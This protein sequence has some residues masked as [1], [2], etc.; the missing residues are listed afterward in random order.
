MPWSCSKKSPQLEGCG[1]QEGAILRVTRIAAVGILTYRNVLCRGANDALGTIDFITPD[2]IK[3]AAS[4]ARQ[5]KVLSRA[6]PFDS[7]GPQSGFA[8]RVNPL[9][10]MFGAPPLPLTGA[11]GSP[12]NP[13]ALQ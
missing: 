1:S 5:A 8:G 13:Q 2:K 12:I 7:N 3:A 4:L 9:H 10:Y 11:V 6:I